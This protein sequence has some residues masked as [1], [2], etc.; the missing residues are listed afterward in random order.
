M[1]HSNLFLTTLILSAALQPHANAS[2]IYANTITA[3][4]IAAIQHAVTHT[5]FN[6][7]EGAMSASLGLQY[8][9]PAQN[10]DPSKTYGRAPMYGRAA[11][12]GE[13]NDD[14]TAGRSGGNN[15][16]PDAALNSIWFS[17]EHT[18]DK[19]KF[20]DYDRI[21]SDFD[22]VMMGLSGGKSKMSNGITQWGIYTGY[23]GGHQRNEFLNIDE[24]GGYF[25][26]YN[27]FNL[28][29]F[30][31]STSINGGVLDNNADNIFGTD[32]FTNFWLGAV[33]NATVNIPLDNTFTIQPGVQLGY[34]WI[35]SDDYTS[36]SGDLLTNDAF[37]MFE[38]SPTLRAIKHIDNGWYGAL[39][40]KHVMIF[41]NGG[42]LNVN[43]IR[44]QALDLD[45]FTEYS[46]SLEKAVANV[47][48]TANFGRRDG[49][50]NGWIG[51]T[52]IKF[53]F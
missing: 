3:Y 4:N 50:H 19:V 2:Q 25:G 10:E 20:D 1:K 23:I 14:G 18:D 41:A 46:I 53:R 17:W 28:G 29:N 32:S 43:G 44:A 38:I 48:F 9:H 39:S 15:T 30:N 8:E 40:V 34:T 42:D 51:G 24:Q 52:N 21:H 13:H 12:Y 37:N 49:S 5:A 33:A 35:K 47:T 22:L 16:N 7:F 36:A 26:L 11:T 27:G 45:N 31:L 6:S